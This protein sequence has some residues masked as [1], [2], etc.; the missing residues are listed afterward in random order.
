M[1]AVRIHRFGDESVLQLDDVPVPVPGPGEVL[2]KVEAAAL[3][4]G[5]LYIRRFGNTHIAEADLPVTL[6]REAAGIIVALGAEVEANRAPTVREGPN[7]RDPAS[8]STGKG[9][10]YVPGQRVVITPGLGGYAEYAV[11]KITETAP[12]PEGMDTVQAAAA[13]WVFLTAWFALTKGGGLKAGELVLIQAGGSGLGTAAIQIARHLGAR[14]LTTAG[15]DARCARTV[16]LGADAAIN[17]S[18]KDLVPEVMRLTGG[19]GVDVVLET[20]GGEMYFKCLR[21]L[22]EGGRLVSIGRAGGEFPEPAPEPPPGRTAARFSI[23]AVLEDDPNAIR[24]LDVLLGM[25]HKGIFR[26]VVDRTFPL[27]QAAEAHRYLGGRNAFGK[28]VLTV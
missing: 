16:E 10:A 12:V 4:G 9:A 5:D 15:T 6:G 25:V 13:P 24:Q 19:R 18:E 8:P 21:V 14:L 28:V 11:A 26:A 27:A 22:A 23:S 20:V 2:V 7:P 1:K 3:N 17:Y